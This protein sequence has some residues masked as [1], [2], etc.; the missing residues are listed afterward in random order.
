MVQISEIW[1]FPTETPCHQKNHSRYDPGF[2]SGRLDRSNLGG[3]PPKPK[4]RHGRSKGCMSTGGLGSKKM[5]SS[6]RSQ[7]RSVSKTSKSIKLEKKSPKFKF[8]IECVLKNYLL[9]DFLDVSFFFKRQNCQNPTFFF[10]KSRQSCGISGTPKDG[11]GGNSS[12]NHGR[13]RGPPSIC[14]GGVMAAIMFRGR[15]DSSTRRTSKKTN[16]NT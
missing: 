16:Q 13:P 14:G 12:Q 2:F 10:S 3:D 1:S 11:G 8:L 9:L 5:V 7:S 15:S 4:P 6:I